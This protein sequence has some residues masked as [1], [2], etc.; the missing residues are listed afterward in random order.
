[1]KVFT[2]ASGIMWVIFDVISFNKKIA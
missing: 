1:M 2:A